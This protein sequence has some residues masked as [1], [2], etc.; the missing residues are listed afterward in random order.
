MWGAYIHV[1]RRNLGGNRGRKS[2]AG[3]SS[4]KQVRLEG[5]E[6]GDDHDDHDQ[7]DQHDYHDHHGHAHDNDYDYQVQIHDH[8]LKY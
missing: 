1:D 8:K 6:H 2:G 4:C 3:D 5:G 7:H